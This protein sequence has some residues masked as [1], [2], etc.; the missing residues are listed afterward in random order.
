MGFRSSVIVEETN[1]KWP[2]WFVE[3]YKEYVHFSTN[4]GAIATI[5]EKKLYSTLAHLFKDIQ[6]VLRTNTNYPQQLN[7]A[8]LH[9]CGGVTRVEI[10]LDKIYY[11]VPTGWEIMSDGDTDHNY[12]YGCSDA[13]HAEGFVK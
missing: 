8:E 6:K 1:I 10:H 4:S 9:E 12:C 3:K 11:T 13:K 7:A 2:K 5:G